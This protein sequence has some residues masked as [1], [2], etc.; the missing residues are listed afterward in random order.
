M[1]NDMT[2][3]RLL[4]IWFTAV[5]LLVVAG[6]ALGASVTMGTGAILLALCLVPPAMIIKLWPSSQPQTI[7]QVLHQTERK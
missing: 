2:R 3:S 7:A 4:Q 1:F 5:V 6:F